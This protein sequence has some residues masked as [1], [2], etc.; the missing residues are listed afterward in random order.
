MRGAQV[1]EPYIRE[2]APDLIIVSAGFDA[3]KGDLLGGMRLSPACY[4]APPPPESA[5]SA[6]MERCACLV[7]ALD[8]VLR[9]DA[10]GRIE[11]AHCTAGSL[12]TQV[13]H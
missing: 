10:S 1:I 3:A 11:R 6:A 5:C 9:T 4:G 12:S 8:A 7:R 2:L 13:C